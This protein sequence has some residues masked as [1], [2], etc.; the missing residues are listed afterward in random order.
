MP[1]FISIDDLL[2]TTTIVA[3]TNYENHKNIM[4]GSTFINSYIFQ[5]QI[6]T[7][8]NTGAIIIIV[9]LFIV[10]RWWHSSSRNPSLRISDEHS[11]VDEFAEHGL[12]DP[13][14]P[15]QAAASEL[16]ANAPTK[17]PRP[18][19]FNPEFERLVA[20]VCKKACAKYC[21]RYI[22]EYEHKKKKR[23]RDNLHI[24]ERSR[25]FKSSLI[26]C[27]IASTFYFK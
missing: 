25:W 2:K 8:M 14:S 21:E 6:L 27:S 11:G 16:H 22:A 20:S 7:Y 10:A 17:A 23:I 19:E 18:P 26:Y 13:L 24:R 5:F 1:R 15:E 4:S 3:R 12:I 9:A